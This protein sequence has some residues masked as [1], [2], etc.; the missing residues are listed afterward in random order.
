ME[1]DDLKQE[2]KQTPVK[3]IK[4]TDIMELIQ[5]KSYGPVAA[6]KK[7]FRRQ[8]VVMIILPVLLFV[9]NMDDGNKALTSVMFWSYVAFCMGVVI[10]SYFNYRI[11]DK[12]GDMDSMVKSNLVRQIG[13]LEA[14]M[15][16]NV[17]GSRIVLPFFILLTEIVPYFQYYRMLDKWHSLHP[18]IRFGAYAFLLLL[19]YFLSRRICQQKYGRHIAYLKSL[20]KEMQ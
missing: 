5:H 10:S 7:A 9:T 14:R 20:V 19:H 11:V 8:I 12:M 2:W 13:L 17:I 4:N 16:W 3:K 15:K 1:L 6:L 18:A